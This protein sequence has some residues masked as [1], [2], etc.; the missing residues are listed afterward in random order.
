MGTK[1]IIQSEKTT[2]F[3]NDVIISGVDFWEFE[4]VNSFPPFFFFF[5]F[6]SVRFLCCSSSGHFGIPF[7]FLQTSPP[8][9]SRERS[10]A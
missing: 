6:F 2:Y 5:K 4:K 1:P 9:H 3:Y 7:L 8:G 10:R